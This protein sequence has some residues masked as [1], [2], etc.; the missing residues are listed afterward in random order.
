MDKEHLRG[1]KWP[2][3]FIETLDVSIFTT[4]LIAVVMGKHL[5]QCRTVA[6]QC[7]YS[8]VTAVSEQDLHV[9]IISSSIDINVDYLQSYMTPVVV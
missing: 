1:L 8:T 7:S 3:I 4:E 9:F 2:E 6:A 5:E